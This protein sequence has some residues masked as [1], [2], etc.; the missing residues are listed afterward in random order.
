M[1]RYESKHKVFKDFVK[2]TQNFKNINKSI[3][4]KHQSLACAHGFT[5]NDDIQTGMR[6]APKDNLKLKQLLN[7]TFENEVDNLNE[8]KWL[9]INNYEYRKGLMIVHETF[10]YQIHNIL[11]NEDGFFLLCKQFRVVSFNSFLNSFKIDEN[12]AYGLVDL[13]NLKNKKTYE[14]RTIESNRYVVV[15][16]LELRNYLRLPE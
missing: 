8:I 3:A 12:T 1:T 14:I 15:E 5:Y 10:L 16:S 13:C 9:R 2:N 7:D 4:M 11:E 6:V